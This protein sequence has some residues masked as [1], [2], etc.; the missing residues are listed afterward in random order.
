MS[1]RQGDW[2]CGA[3]QHLNF[4]KRDLCQRCSCPKYASGGDLSSYALQKN[5]LQAGDWY[6]AALNCG[7]HN[8]ASRTS[9]YRCCAS[10]DYC[11]YGAGTMAS[12][13]YG[14][15]AIPGWKTGDWI[16]TSME[17]VNNNFVAIKGHISGAPTES[18][19]EIK[20]EKVSLLARD[21][22]VIVQNL[23]VSVDPYQLNR[24]KNHS[25]SHA[26]I[27]FAVP[28]TPGHAID[29]YGAGRVL[30][31]G[32]PD[33]V[34]DELVV[35]LLSWGE[36]TV[37][38]QGRL[39]NKL[40]PMGLPL[41]HHVGALEAP[42]EI[43]ARV[44][45]NEPWL[46]SSS[47]SY[48]GFFEVCKPKK[49]ESVFVSSASGSVGSLV[50]QYAKLFGCHV[51]GC[52]G[53]QEKVD[54]LKEKLGF[55]DAFNYK[56]ETNLNSALKRY[57]PKGIDIYFDNVGGE[58]LEAA[59]ANMNKFGRVA[60]CGAISEYT[61][62]GRKAYLE[63]LHVVYNRITIQGFLAADYLKC[64]ADFISI[65]AQHLHTGK[66]KALCDISHGVESVPRAFIG[67]FRGDNIGKKIVQ[68]ADE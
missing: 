28:I 66:M 40:D 25:S 53:T 51:V 8:Y 15:D 64:Y 62:G 45:K 30:A 57:F 26:A 21:G 55:D 16:C 18:D 58:M 32:R 50:G 10:K 19:F 5:Q 17:E 68:I 34:K 14:Y 61:G 48:G 6:C 46:I 65:T 33:F 60:V 3:C 54:L 63:M 38:E 29:T 27:N 4:Q 22:E 56:D 44:K 7:A 11:G 20:T 39:L 67:I 31:S 35:G 13:G 24:M 41:S 42:N 49:G 9:C 23:Y 47:K 43:G 37:V 52:A 12:A 36:Y 1:C 2:T 59:V